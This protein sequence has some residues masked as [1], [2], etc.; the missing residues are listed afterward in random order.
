MKIRHLAIAFTLF[1][2]LSAGPSARCET[3]RGE[4]KTTAAVR[5]PRK[6]FREAVELY[7]N[8]LYQQAF[9]AF[10]ALPQDALTEGYMLLCRIK[11]SG[12]DLM[13]A[14]EDYAAK[15]GQTPLSAQIHYNLARY[16]FDA[17]NYTLAARE[18]QYTDVSRLSG[19]E[20]ADLY[21]KSAYCD[22]VDGR[23][24]AARYG[25]ER[26][27]E[28]PQSDYT[29]TANY[30]LGTICYSV[31]EF[32]TAVKHFDACIDD[33]RFRDN[34]LYYELECRFMLKDY[35]YVRE[36]GE[37]VYY[38]IPEQR[39][40]HL[41]RII[42]ESYLV[43]GDAG[44]A[45]EYYSMED[46]DETA[47]SRADHFYAGSLQYALGDYEGSVRHYKQM[48]VVK[49]SLA[50]VA[51][52]QLGYSYIKL[53]DKV[54]ALNSFKAACE[55][56]FRKDIREDALFNYAKLAFD[57][58]RDTAPFK[59]Y[60]ASYPNA[61]NRDRLYYY[62]A[63]AS[64]V[65]RDY[66]AAV[67]AY[68]NIDELDSDMKSNY[69]KANFL[70]AKELISRG[71]W[72]DA[73]PCL[74]AAAYYT[75]R[76][77]NFNKLCRYWLAECYYKSGRYDEA[78]KVYS[79]LYNLSALDRYPE[80]DAI[81]YNLAYC[82][83]RQNDFPAA[84]RWF[85]NYLQGGGEAHRRDASL[86]KADC[87]FLTRDYKGAA[88]AYS[89]FADEFGLSESYYPL[90]QQ[91]MSCG[92]QGQMRQKTEVMRPILQGDP[93][94]PFYSDALFELGRAYVSLNLSGEA[95]NCF[96]ILR[97]KSADRIYPARALI[98]MGM[99]ERNRRNYDAAISCYRQVVGEYP[100]SGYRD[101]ALLS[102]ESV[103][104][105]KGE[106]G[107][108]IAY[109]ESLGNPLR[110]SEGD[111]EMI[112]YNTAE[113]MYLAE[114]YDKALTALQ[115]YISLYP[116]GSKIQNARFYMGETLRAMGRKEQACTWYAQVA[117]SG[118]DSS[119]VELSI[120]NYAVLSYGL[121]RFADAYGAYSS[122]L[123]CA[124]VENNTFVAKIGMMRSAFRGRNYTEAIK[125]C[126]AVRTDSRSDEALKREADYVNAKSL[127]STSRRD[128]AFDI[129]KKLAAAPGTPEGA[130][131]SYMI[132]QDTY[133]RGLFDQIE[134]KVY[135][136]ASSAGDQSYWLA[137]AF[138]VLGDSFVERDN[139]AQA[140]A[141]FESV[142]GG[143]EPTG[144]DDEVPSLVQMRLDKLNELM[145][146]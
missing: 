5:L 46:V 139:L 62:M 57:L 23:M 81:I 102:L 71:S 40:P 20:K 38:N 137:K 116:E 73:V 60:I 55:M 9:F 24:D 119:L 47:M 78:A 131:A 64:L 80:G 129:L 125:A 50:Q 52:Y 124:K 11:N 120:L 104:Q 138:I 115:N 101:E 91:G 94:I 4:D 141:T 90:Y 103:Y 89:A 41:A 74:K 3:Y 85:T 56:P 107:K 59:T 133:D 144:E 96:R 146:Q 136:F 109:M 19:R 121:D 93:N 97:E 32:G 108:Y 112:Y 8:A 75:P 35:E 143:Y 27:L 100:E 28:L 135:S 110:R 83:F 98:E 44:K 2:A 48:G 87:L 29:A 33:V 145:Q 26:V 49:D 77:D 114:D 79:D 70:R 140:K 142:Q 113:Q 68:D 39:R 84:S 66:A 21:M 31:H 132:I 130:E 99:I 117:E 134:D 12:E 18:F 67:E 82:Y 22:Y 122:L 127:L 65:D 1:A 16:F 72:S 37:E 10:S 34:A 42:S 6:A 123:E 51:A 106:P 111:K 126:E 63:L 92:L 54:S 95:Y 86:R 45:A 105:A 53:K 128:E 76:S 14:S 25:F 13:T 17:A 61:G 30:F 88:A 58:N 69:M 118:D 7:E 15:Y 43:L 36:H